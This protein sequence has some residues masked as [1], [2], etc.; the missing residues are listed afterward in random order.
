MK[1]LNNFPFEMAQIEIVSIVDDII[2]TSK[3]PFPGE[4]DDF[5]NYYWND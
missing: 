2:T 5:G 3:D 4:D 1:K